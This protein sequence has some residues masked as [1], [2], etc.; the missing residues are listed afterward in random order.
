MSIELKIAWRYFLGKGNL[1]TINLIS[2]TTLI[3]IA[4][5]VMA[6][7]III[8][9]FNGFEKIILGNYNQFEP[10][11]VIE[12][13]NK[14]SFT[15]QNAQWINEL[16]NNSSFSEIR[17]CKEINVV[18]EHN[19]KQVIATL[20]GISTYNTFLKKVSSKLEYNEFVPNSSLYATAILG[21]GLAYQLKLSNSYNNTPIKVFI[22]NPSSSFNILQNN[23]VLED[24]IYVG[25]TFFLQQ[26][27]D[28]KYILTPLKF[29]HGLD[30][31]RQD[32]NKVELFVNKPQEIQNIKESLSKTCGPNFVVKDSI[33]LHSYIKS[34]LVSEKWMVF[35]IL[36]FVLILASFNIIGSLVMLILFKKE[37]LFTFQTM[38]MQN[39]ALK[40]IF[41]YNGI[42]INVSGIVLGIILGLLVCFI[43]L[44]FSIV[45]LGNEGSF[46]VNAYPVE[47]HFSDLAIIAS[48]VFVIGFIL[49]YLPTRKVI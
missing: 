4:T 9:V 36:L 40:K 44:K 42:F 14:T 18:L 17:Y 3:G 13:V 5:C 10:D 31:L 35:A 16:R 15:I 28:T 26:E 24:K 41:L 49:S 43:Q 30:T 2:R 21:A 11:L 12:N 48:T 8:S 6:M 37:E 32:I 22:P 45:T 1:K 29:I 47:I 34:I 25:A 23:L 38:G 19:K 33:E 27:F 39:K 20:K 7:V 46:L